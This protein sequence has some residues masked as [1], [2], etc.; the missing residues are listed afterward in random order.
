MKLSMLLAATLFR[1]SSGEAH[2]EIIV[3]EQKDFQ[4]SGKSST[5][6]SNS[7]SSGAP[8]TQGVAILSKWLSPDVVV[9]HISFGYRYIT[10]Y[11]T[12]RNPTNGANFTVRAMDK[13]IYQS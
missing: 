2:T 9:Q 4:F 13:I 3:A 8:H 11:G 1:S 6:G 5:S 10:G 12:F 7:I